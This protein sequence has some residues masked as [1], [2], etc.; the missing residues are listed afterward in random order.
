MKVSVVMVPRMSVVVVW[1]EARV[2]Q[3]RSSTPDLVSLKPLSSFSA[4]HQGKEH[5]RLNNKLE[6]IIYG[7]IEIQFYH[8]IRVCFDY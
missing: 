1:R 7:L 4:S 3:S 5:D 8:K 2:C 6:F